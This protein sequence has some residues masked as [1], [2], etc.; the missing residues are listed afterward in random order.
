[1]TG[2]MLGQSLH[3]MILRK[4]LHTVG[5]DVDFNTSLL[6]FEQDANSVKAEIS[7]T[8]DGKKMIA[9]TKFACVI[10]MDGARSESSL[11]C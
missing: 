3:Q 9:H 5:T 4:R 10:G 8:E 11:V 2:V 7:R 1:M 6:G